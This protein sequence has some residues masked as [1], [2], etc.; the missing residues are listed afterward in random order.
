VGA[1][2]VALGAVEAGLEQGAEDREVDGGPVLGGGA[3]DQGE[4]VAGQRGRVDGGEQ[5]GV[6][7][8]EEGGGRGEGGGEAR[9]V[10]EQGVEDPEDESAGRV[11]IGAAVDQAIVQGGEGVGGA[12]RGGVVRGAGGAGGDGG[13]V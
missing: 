5:A 2:G 12:A 11:A 8:G 1:E 13:R 6:R 9:G 3:G 10:D 7:A 4:V